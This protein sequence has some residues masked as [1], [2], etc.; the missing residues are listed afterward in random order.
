MDSKA[1]PAPINVICVLPP[2]PLPEAIVPPLP[3]HWVRRNVAKPADIDDTVAAGADA[4]LLAVHS[5]MERKTLER[6]RG[7][8][9]LQWVGVGLDTIDLAA[10][11]ELGIPVANVVAAN[12]VAVAEY[13]ILATMYLMRRFGDVMELA[14]AERMPWPQAVARGMHQVRGKSLGILSYGDIGHE[15]AKG[16]TGLGM[17]VLTASIPGRERKPGA[18]ELELGVE[19]LGFQELIST[20]DVLVLVLPLVP[21]TRNLFDRERLLQMKKGSYLVNAARGGIVDEQA[22]ADVLREGHLAGAAVDTFLVEPIAK[23]HPLWGAPNVLLTPHCGGNTVE[24]TRYVGTEAFENINRVGR[25]E[26][27]RSRVC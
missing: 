22:L 16:A 7:I 3:A 15:I 2:G 27:P 18:N 10:A 12:S 20:C 6:L 11:R 5:P 26:P 14:R 17:K 8:K 1:S 24:A 21:E 25:G 23:D 13:A 9:L 4:V 19:R